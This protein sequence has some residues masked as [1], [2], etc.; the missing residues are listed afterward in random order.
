MS[1]EWALSKSM[2]Y[3]LVLVMLLS[4][5][6]VPIVG[7]AS[8]APIVEVNHYDRGDETADS[9]EQWT[10]RPIEELFTS[11]SCSPCMA[12]SEPVINQYHDEY[13]DD[14]SVPF[15]WIAFHQ[16]NGGDGDDPLAIQ[17]SKDRYSFYSVV[18][19]P[20]GEFDGGFVSSQDH[21]AAMDESGTR[22]VANSQLEVYQEWMGD[23]WRFEVNLTYGG[24][25]DWNPL[26]D[27]EFTDTLDYALYLFVIEDD[28]LAYSSQEGMEVITHNVHRATVIDDDQGSLAI[29]ETY[30]VVADWSIPETVIMSGGA[31]APIHPVNAANISVVAVVYDRDDNAQGSTPNA[32]QGLPRAINSATPKSTAYDMQNDIPI[33]TETVETLR[34]ND[35]ELM[36]FFDDEQGISGAQVVWNTAWVDDSGAKQ[37]SDWTIDAMEIKGDE[38]CDENGVCYSYGNAAATATIL[39]PEGKEINYQ[40]MFTDGAHISNNTDVQTFAGTSLDAMG[41]AGGNWVL[42]IAGGGGLFVM[43]ILGFFVVWAR[44][45]YQGTW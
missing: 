45:P 41:D 44:M 27:L 34:G 21:I 37:T 33:V 5:T 4:L 10:H 19:T 24:D 2:P 29:D 8:D 43:L 42:W 35:A 6:T 31:E 11:L 12:N 13:R 7:A 14:P 9:M 28:V 22:S 36:V 3:A 32:K 30:T 23:G 15:T 25:D 16:T 1:K 38:I 40:V 20:D 18:G 26:L 39:V 17:A